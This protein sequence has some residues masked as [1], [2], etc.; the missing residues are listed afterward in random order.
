LGKKYQL[1]KITVYWQTFDVQG[2]IDFKEGKPLFYA[3]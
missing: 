3:L 1:S 2:K